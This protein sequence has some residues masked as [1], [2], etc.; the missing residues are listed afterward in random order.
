MPATRPRISLHALSAARTRRSPARWLEVLIAVALLGLLGASPTVAAA[1][2]ARGS[3]QTFQQRNLVSDIAGV[4]RITDRNLVNPWG[5]AAGP[6]SPLWVADN[7]SDLSTLYTGAVN[8]SVPR[9]LPLVV[10]IP[11]GAPTGIVFNPTRASSSTPA[12]RAR[13]RTSS[14]TPR[15]ARSPPGAE[16]CRR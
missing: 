12:R 6:T 14:S 16:P 15:P 3:H 8:G 10:G 11:D 9:T 5:L 1:H 2:G 13:R 4:A 7:G